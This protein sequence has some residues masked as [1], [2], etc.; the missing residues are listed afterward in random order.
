MEVAVSLRTCGRA[1]T[2]ANRSALASGTVS[3]ASRCCLRQRNSRFAFTPFSSLRWR[4]VDLL[5]NTITVGKSKTEGGEGRVIPLSGMAAA[6]LREWRSL[7]PGAQPG[8]CV[9]PSE[10]YGL[11]GEDG[12]QDGRVVAYDVRPGSSHRLMEGRMDEDA[13]ASGRRVPMAR[14]A[15]PPL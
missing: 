5:E 4:Q 6:C 2:G 12:Y 9:F 1:V 15:A 11:A 3:R 10:K 14:H 13:D 7:F 8:H